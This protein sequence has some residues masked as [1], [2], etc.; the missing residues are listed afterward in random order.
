[1]FPN[2]HVEACDTDA[3]AVAIATENARLNG[4]FEKI[5]F[6]VGTVEET[7]ASA[8]L[9]CANLTADMITVMLPSLI[10][11]TC[12]HLVL[13]GILD[14]QSEALRAR[15][16]ECGL[17]EPCETMQDGEWIALVV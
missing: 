8:D 16:Q 4:V 17:S 6:R 3:D 10:S 12:G 5:T 13:S 2:A 15:M 7:T 1:M 11:V 9:V 14:T